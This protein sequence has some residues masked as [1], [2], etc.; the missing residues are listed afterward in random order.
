MVAGWVWS[1][2]R[3]IVWSLIS[4]LVILSLLVANSMTFA[5]AADIRSTLAEKSPNERANIKA[6]ENREQAAGGPISGLDLR[7]SH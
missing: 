1:K 3:Q 4:L 7:T 2:K 6:A 5:A